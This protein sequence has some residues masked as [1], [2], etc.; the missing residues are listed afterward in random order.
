MP[1]GTPPPDCGG[2]ASGGSG[3]FEK[4]SGVVPQ[5][6]FLGFAGQALPGDDVVDRIR[7]L[8]FRMR[9]VGGV[10]Q[11]AVAQ[12]LGD[13]VEHVLA[14]VVLD[15]AEEAPAFHVVARPHLQSAVPPTYT[16]CSS[17]RLAQNGSQPNPPSSTPMRKVGNRSNSPPPINEATKRMA[18]HGWAAARP[19][20]MFS[21]RSR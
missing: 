17:R 10:H 9:I 18:P 6:L 12:K 3:L 7:E 19:I 14:F 21:H 2:E 13:I 20:K 15:A 8:T 1:R 4:M 11:H 16:A 5:Q